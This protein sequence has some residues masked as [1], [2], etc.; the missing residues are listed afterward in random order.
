MK[1]IDDLLNSL[2]DH[3]TIDSQGQFT[4][5]L[6]DAR[7]KLTHFHSSDNSRYLLLLLSAGVAAGAE[8]IDIRHSEKVLEVSLPGAYLPEPDLLASLGE[9]LK[10][11]SAPGAS[12]L[13]LGIQAAFGFNVAVI[14]V[15]VQ[16]P[17]KGSYAWV[18]EPSTERSAPTPSA[19]QTGIGLALHYR[20]TL[21]DRVK[22]LLQSLRG[23]AGMP[24]EIRQVDR[25][26]DLCP[27]P[28]RYQTE[29]ITRQLMLPD[30]P[31]RVQI[32]PL[33]EGLLG[34][35]PDRIMG[36][37]PWRG[38]LALR[39]GSVQLVVHGVSYCRIDSTGLTGVIYGDH[40]KRDVSRERVVQN[41]T[42][43]ALLD[44]LEE[45]RY[46]LYETLAHKLDELEKDELNETLGELILS[47]LNQRL[48]HRAQK[49]VW[50]WLQKDRPG[51]W[52]A[53]PEADFR[54]SPTGL[55]KLFRSAISFP[56]PPLVLLEGLLD[57][58]IEGL[59]QDNRAGFLSRLETLYSLVEAYD[60]NRKLL[61]A[62]YL[63]GIGALH[64]LAGQ[65]N[66]AE[67]AWF[68]SLELV[69]SGQDARA[70]ELIYTHMGFTPTHIVDQVR[71]ALAM[72]LWDVREELKPYRSMFMAPAGRANGKS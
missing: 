69:W 30:A 16:S 19:P 59:S 58:S 28:I 45:V 34:F 9:P 64:S 20:S 61:L 12:D 43:R 7:R 1:S 29:S 17:E 32:G 51:Q 40:L 41:P 35:K 66:R 54:P 39:S 46:Q 14:Q 27:R 10:G 53:R 48:S 3:G 26:C 70:H 56:M 67:K 72:Y 8:R 68:R 33:P 13:A 37:L 22:G 47:F 42:Y 15:Q 52:S 31:A 63:L 60:P 57:E 65:K 62:Y 4:L 55:I 50:N 11:E 21:R 38:A 6:A 24:P 49:T 18:L 36:G 71:T 44:E 25:Y 23:Y 5:S 2:R